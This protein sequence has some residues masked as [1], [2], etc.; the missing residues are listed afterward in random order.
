MITRRVATVLAVAG[1][2]FGACSSGTSSPSPTTAATT[3]PPAT[4]AP[5][6]SASASPTSA[7]GHCA[8]TDINC[9]VFGSTYK[10]GPG[11]PGGTL[12]LGEWQAADQLNPFYTTAFTDVEAYSPALRGLV[13]LDAQGKYLPDLAAKI[14][15]P[16]NGGLVM[17][18][19]GQ[20]YTLTVTLK[21]GLLWSDGTPL[22]M[23]D[24]KYTWTWAN[25]PKQ[26]GCTSCSV[27]YPDIDSINVSTDGLTAT[28]HFKDLFP[29]W[30]NWLAGPILPQHYMSKF[31]MANVAKQSYPVSSAIA[32]AVFSGPFVITNASSSEID[33]ARNTNWKG[34]VSSAHPAY[35]D[36]LKFQYFG[37]QNGEIAAFK[38]GS[39]DLALDLLQD[40]YPAIKTVD[41]SVGSAALT[42]VW[43]YEH[44]DL[45]NDPTHVRQNGLWDINVRKAIA[46]AV[47]KQS[48]INADF[49]GTPLTP[50]CDPVPPTI[51]YAKP[52]TCPA[53]DPA[54]AKALLAQAGWTPDSKGIVSQNGHEMNLL[55]CTTSG[56]PTR[57]T[58][59]QKLA[60]DLQA[61]GI[62]STI[63]TAD[64]GSVVFAGWT[65]TTPTTQ[66]SIYRGTYD[67]ADFA[68]VLTGSPYNDA[69]Y[70]YS[71]SQFP[72]IG[73]HGGSNDTRFSSPQMD[74][75]LAKLATDVSLTAQQKDAG[76]VQDAYVAGIPEIPLYYRS[77]A[78]GT[79]VHLGN[80][81][82]Y[83]P[84]A[85]GPLWDVEDWY[86]KP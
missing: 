86:Y 62:A 79:S 13:T 68:Y 80:W 39:I 16:D 17:D 59:L 63:K 43:E 23:N 67:I 20:G 33:Y 71:S 73:N 34:G 55:L 81:P 5:S 7:A 78:V 30:L 4:T 35:L 54:G 70:T 74:A 22:T 77:E 53:Y 66:C 58:E 51:W 36:H 40:S 72:E 48:I 75:A 37:D 2:V 26:S 6:S 64:A 61:V 18:A 10:P 69:Y 31:T 82:G 21:P 56:N 49:P 46:M 38:S 45:N 8:P 11:T 28:I 50:A 15:T 60:G 12:V 47:D 42:P 27:G 52:E 9:I 76:A 57:L 3:A 44:F 85:N 24:L 29:G 83:A 14:P 25:D 65:S 84:S 41:P 1:L 32:N 19:N